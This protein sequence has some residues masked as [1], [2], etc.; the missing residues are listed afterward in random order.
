[1][2]G[3]HRDGGRTKDKSSKHDRSS[4]AA[5][6]LDKNRSEQGGKSP[7]QDETHSIRETLRMKPPPPRRLAVTRVVPIAPHRFMLAVARLKSR[8]ASS[9]RC[10]RESAAARWPCGCG[11]SI[12]NLMLV[13][14]YYDV[15]LRDFG[16]S[17]GAL[18]LGQLSQQYDRRR[19]FA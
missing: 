13:P 15:A 10:G 6:A 5:V 19:M 18:A 12:V 3:H 11:P 16:L 2:K 1:L 4:V 17:V 7:T 8:R 9:W 14:G